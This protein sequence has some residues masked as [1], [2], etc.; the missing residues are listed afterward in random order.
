MTKPAPTHTHATAATNTSV[1]TAI[2]TPILEGRDNVVVA[3]GMSGAVGLGLGPAASVV[4]FAENVGG[5]EA[6]AVVDGVRCDD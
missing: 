5:I 1:L 4:E 2:L 3:A 6:D